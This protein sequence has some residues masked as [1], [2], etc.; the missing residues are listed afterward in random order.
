VNATL[1][2]LALLAA[3]GAAPKV[4]TLD[5]AA[6]AVR[7]HVSHKLHQV[8]GISK[9]AEGKAILEAN[10]AVR[11]MVRIPVQSFDSGD[12]NRDSHMLETLQAGQHPYVVFKGVGTLPP[13]APGVPV[14]VTLRGELDFHGV[15]R[16]VEVPVTVQ[17]GTDGSARVQGKLTVS[18][19]AYQIERPSLLLVKLDDACTIAFDLKL[20]RSG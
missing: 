19:E 12:A 17:F 20:G 3:T 11:T 8:D 14:A 13:A 10:G 4:L 18:L 9:G 6:S 7:F 16:P 1:A 5:P 15:K 2:T